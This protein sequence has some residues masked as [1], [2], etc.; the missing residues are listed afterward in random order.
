MLGKLYTNMDRRCRLTSLPEAI[1]ARSSCARSAIG[2]ASWARRRPSRALLQAVRALVREKVRRPPLVVPGGGFRWPA[3]G[4]LAHPGPDRV[5]LTRPHPGAGVLQR[6]L[7]ARLIRGLR[8]G[9]P[10]PQAAQVHQR[11]WAAV[12][13]QGP[14]RLA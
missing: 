14:L 13:P 8:I 5:Q 1:R 10:L 2:F 12:A 9:L 4:D 6:Y 3:V 11:P 7:P